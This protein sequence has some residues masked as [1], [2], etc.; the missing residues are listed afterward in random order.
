MHGPTS[1]L[2][3]ATQFRA[4]QAVEKEREADLQL[5]AQ[6]VPVD[7]FRQGLKG[8]EARIMLSLSLPS[9]PKSA[10]LTSDICWFARVFCHTPGP[11]GIVGPPCGG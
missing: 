4:V 5:H 10:I 6:Q 1:C 11:R 7:D 8:D 3:K 2:L 9:L